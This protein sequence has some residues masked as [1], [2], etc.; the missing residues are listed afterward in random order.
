MIGTQDGTKLEPN[1]TRRE[2]T[3]KVRTPE[4]EGVAQTAGRVARPLGPTEGEKQNHG[5]V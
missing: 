3:P 1:Q 2:A 5:A 4:R